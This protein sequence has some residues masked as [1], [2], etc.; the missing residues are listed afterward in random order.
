MGSKRIEMSSPSGVW[1]WVF[2]ALWIGM[3]TYA[4]IRA[5]SHEDAD[6][7]IVLLLV[8]SMVPALVGV[9]LACFTVTAW[10]SLPIYQRLIGLIPV[11]YILALIVLIVGRFL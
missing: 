7:R 11:V 4:I 2:F 1:W 3:Q 5:L 6:H 8:F 9:A 10:R